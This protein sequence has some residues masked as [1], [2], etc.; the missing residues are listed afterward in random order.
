MNQCFTKIEM[1]DRPSPK[2]LQHYSSTDR[3][4]F[5]YKWKAFNI[6]ATI[7]I[8]RAL[9]IWA[10]ASG[11]GVGASKFRQSWLA[12]FI[13]GFLP[14]GQTESRVLLEFCSLDWWLL[15]DQNQNHHTSRKKTLQYQE[16]SGLLSCL[17]ISILTHTFLTRTQRVGDGMEAND[18][19]KRRLKASHKIYKGNCFRE[20]ELV[21]WNVPTSRQS[22]W[23][24]ARLK[25]SLHI[26][27]VL[28]ASVDWEGAKICS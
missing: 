13:G 26:S 16:M 3:T 17:G 6:T 23:N 2:G 9:Q 10:E 21:P 25:V 8:I 4:F 24:V 20:W 7:I 27:T 22:N 19:K 5:N 15:F 12:T 28:Q 14:S 18:A 1:L 11:I